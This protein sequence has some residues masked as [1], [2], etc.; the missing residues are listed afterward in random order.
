MLGNWL[1][2]MLETGRWEDVTTR[3]KALFDG[4]SGLEF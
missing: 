1:G 3:E 2:T 4:E